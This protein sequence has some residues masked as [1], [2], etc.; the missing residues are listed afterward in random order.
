MYYLC[1]ICTICTKIVKKSQNS[2]IR[3][4]VYYAV[5]FLNYFYYLTSCQPWLYFHY[6]HLLFSSQ[7]GKK[8]QCI[9]DK[10]Q[11]KTI[12]QM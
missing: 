8:N 2:Q 7:V 10:A 12:K 6:S 4:F 3:R 1:T 11:Y 9:Q 5:L